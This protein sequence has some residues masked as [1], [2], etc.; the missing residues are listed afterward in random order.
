MKDEDGNMIPCY[1]DITTHEWV[2]ET[3]ESDT[4]V[5][6]ELE[7]DE[8][9]YVVFKNLPLRANF[10]GDEPDYTKSYYLVETQAPDGF[11]LLSDPVEIRLPDDGNT[12]FTYTVK[13]DTV[14][15]TLEAGGT[16]ANMYYMFGGFAIAIGLLAVG[17]K[18]RIRKSK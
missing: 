5:K 9:G 18:K 3:K 2:N 8:N 14:T 15:L 12:E 10:T 11:N 6:M 13:D 17:M 7:T 4:V 16:G 1:M